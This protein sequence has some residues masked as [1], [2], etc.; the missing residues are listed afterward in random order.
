MFEDE[1]LKLSKDLSDVFREN[2]KINEEY[3]SLYNETKLKDQSLSAEIKQKDS[4]IA[5]LTNKIN[6]LEINIERYEDN[7]INIRKN[8]DNTV[9]EYQQEISRKNDDIKFMIESHSKEIKEVKF[10]LNKILTL[11]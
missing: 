9:Y 3:V 11:T 4:E 10:Q 2:E 5:Q 7:L 1:N 6:E 8:Y